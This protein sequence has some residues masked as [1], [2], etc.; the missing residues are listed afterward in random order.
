[1]IRYLFFYIL[2]LSLSSCSYIDNW[3]R[4]RQA[5]TW[6][7]RISYMETVQ[8]VKTAAYQG[9][10]FPSDNPSYMFAGKRFMPSQLS[11]G[12]AERILTEQWRKAGGERISKELSTYVR[13]YVGYTNEKGEKIIWINFVHEPTP[14]Y[15]LDKAIYEMK[16][17]GDSFWNVKVNLTTHQLFELNVNGDV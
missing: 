10:I 16:D 1:M 14:G 15:E 6:K 7:E 8:I 9:Y 2:L 11:V 5:R 12:M 13:Q 4:E 3:K 17:G